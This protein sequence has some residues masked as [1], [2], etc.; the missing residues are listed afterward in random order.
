MRAHLPSSSWLHTTIPLAALALAVWAQWGGGPA[1][2][3]AGDEWLRDH[4]VRMQASHTP[5]PRI[6]V[7]DI[8][9]ASLGDHPWPWSRDRLAELVET[10]LESGARA[11][12]LDILQGKPGDPGGDARLAALAHQGPLVLAQVFDY[13]PRTQALRF[14]QPAGGTL[15][16][17]GTA[18]PAHGYMA[19]HAGLARAPHVGN[20]GMRPDADG[21]LRRVP[22]YTWFEGRRY[23]TLSRALLDCCA[24]RPATPAAPG[25]DDGWV[26]V[27]FSRAHEAYDVASA[28]AVLARRIPEEW[29]AGRLVL[30]GSSSLSIGDRVATPLDR[31]SAGLLVHASMLTNLLDRQAGLA[32]A[33]WPGALLSV[34]FAGA[35]ALLAAYTFA[36]RSAAFNVALLAAAS[37]AW[38]LAAYVISPHDPVFAVSG[39][40]MSI[41]F[42]LSVGVPF[43]WQMAQSGSR[44]LLDTMR[45][46]VAGAVVDELL[47]SGLKDPL[48]PRHLQVTT[49]IADMQGYT[50]QVEALPVE[51][52]A[53]LTTDFL[54]CLTRP[55]LDLHGTLDKYTGDGL[56]AFWG[57]PIPNDEHAD[58]ALDAARRILQEVQ[59]FSQARVRAGFQ[60]LRVRIG[61]ESGPAMVGDF[62][63][64]FRSIYT[65]VGD[66]VN[67]AS[68]LEQAARD[69]PCDVVIGEGTVGYARR[70]RFVSLGQH[71]LRGKEKTIALYTLDTQELPT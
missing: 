10:L 32:P 36:R 22:M 50:T 71:A 29:I 12:A 27:S 57:A 16:P 42:L 34:L 3:A 48:A 37:L 7:V 17:P 18:V 60:P 66:S 58:L 8:D 63:T 31:S 19:N 28:G 40:L 49:L 55:V 53:R 5:E 6:L 45:R 56:V 38:L 2:L 21:V 11:V 33:R 4:F 67:T 44:R 15:A 69:L 70:H 20:I 9:E 23:P 54:D 14:G 59:R 13:A 35:V 43:H 68:R 62:G 47:R 25:P 46:Y 52:A 1:P 41:M 65:A 24:A 61:I 64:A 26:R 30:I 39:P 51:D